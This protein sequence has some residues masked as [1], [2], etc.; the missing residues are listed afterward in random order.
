MKRAKLTWAMGIAPLLV[1]TALPSAAQLGTLQGK[2]PAT[3]AAALPPA[4][5]GGAQ[6]PQTIVR[7]QP[8]PPPVYVVFNQYGNTNFIRP[9]P[10]SE[11]RGAYE[12]SPNDQFHFAIPYAAAAVRYAA[13]S[14]F[15]EL[16]TAVQPITICD[17]STVDG[18]TPAGRHPGAAHDGGVNFDVTYYM[19]RPGDAVN[20]VVCPIN[21]DGHCTGP[22]TDLDAPR[23]AYF[24]ACLGRL[25][26]ELGGRL[27]SKM[28]VD[29]WVQAAVTPELDRLEA[30]GTFTPAAI[31]RARKLVYSE[32]VDQ[33]TGWFRF[34]HNHTHL[35]FQWRQ[36]DAGW[37]AQ[38]I[39]DHIHGFLALKNADARTNVTERVLGTREELPVPHAAPPTRPAPAPVATRPKPA[40]PAAKPAATEGFVLSIP[41]SRTPGRR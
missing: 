9:F 21:E 12:F 26:M 7:P 5:A 30:K 15:R 22:A 28:A 27:L 24:F 1:A 40:A 2:A 32:A 18:E 31:G 34:H 19:K 10:P 16:G 29:A 4:T 8:A 37:M 41:R 35:R 36:A 3:P 39:N 11:Y 25:D 38:R 13:Y 20:Y 6:A 23:Q 33:G 17:C 14:T